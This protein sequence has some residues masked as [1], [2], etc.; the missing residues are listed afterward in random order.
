M[1]A[2][3]ASVGCGRWV[4][5]WDVGGGCFGEMGGGHPVPISFVI[6]VPEGGTATNIG[7]P[8]GGTVTNIGV[9]EGGTVTNIGMPEGGT[10]TNTGVPQGGTATNRN[11][12]AA[13]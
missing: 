2:V 13:E 10:A 7:V 1:W 6:G 3:G 11:G 4:L 5:R 8:E 9:P 12:A